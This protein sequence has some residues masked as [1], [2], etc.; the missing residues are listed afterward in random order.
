MARNKRTL[1]LLVCLAVLLLYAFVT[2]RHGPAVPRGAFGGILLATLLFT[3]L[4]ACVA[5]I[6][7]SLIR[8]F[9]RRKG[10]KG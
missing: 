5:C 3:I 8:V 6:A 9:S 7:V 4:A 10:G 2:D 1:L